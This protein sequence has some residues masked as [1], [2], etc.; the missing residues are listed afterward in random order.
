MVMS[1]LFS[2]LKFSLFVTSVVTFP[3][4]Q[5]ALLKPATTLRML[6]RMQ[7]V[8]FFAFFNFPN[9]NKAK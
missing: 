4:N 8:F 5:T 1:N 2:R 3:I 6:Y 7:F 9:E